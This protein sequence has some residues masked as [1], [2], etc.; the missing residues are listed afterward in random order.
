MDTKTRASFELKKIALSRM[1]F[2]EDNKITFTYI[3]NEDEKKVHAGTGDYEGIVNEGRSIEGV[4]V[5]IFLHER[6]DG[7]FK[8][9]LRSNGKVNVSDVCLVFGGGGHP[10]A[11]G[12]T[13]LNMTPEEIRDKVAQ[14]VKR[15]L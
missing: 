5:S 7:G 3:T 2:L 4:E 8:L 10:F 1:E 6:E 13:I 11:A 15:Q 12:A 14:E 9:S